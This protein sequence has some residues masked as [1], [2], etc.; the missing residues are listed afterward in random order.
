VEPTRGGFS[1]ISIDQTTFGKGQGN[2]FQACVASILELPLEEV[3][4]FCKDENPYWF[5]DLEDWLLPMGLAPMLV[6]P[7]TCSALDTTYSIAGGPAA[8]GL[9]HSVVVR[10]VEVVHDP[11]PSRSGLVE[12]KD[13]M[14]FIAI[15]PAAARRGLATAEALP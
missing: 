3:P 5:R 9:M 4:H 15:D 6:S 1:V 2:C 7:G 13:Y 14:F 11:H 10:G 8:R 12:V